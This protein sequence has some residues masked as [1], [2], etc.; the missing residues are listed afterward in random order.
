MKNKL[1]ILLNSNATWSPSGYGQ[2]AGQFLPLMAGDGHEC[3][4]IAYDGL[5]A[6][7]INIGG[8]TYLPRI[9]DPYG[10]DAILEHADRYKPDLIFTLQDVWTINNLALKY[11]KDN[12]FKWV[13]IVPV[14]HEPVPSYILEKL[15][16]A[17]RIITISRF[18]HD[19]L[20]KNGFDST[21]I[22]HTVDTGMFRRMEQKEC[23]KFIGVPDNVFLFGMVA[24]NKENPPRKSFQQVLDAFKLFR[25]AQPGSAIY[26][27]TLMDSVDGFPI[28]RYAKFL[29]LEKSVYHS[30]RY[31]VLYD[32]KQEEMPR[33]Y[34]A[35]DVL[36][37]P[38][39]RE[40]FG[41]PIIEAQACEVPAIVNDFTSMRELVNEGV[42]GYKVKVA[43]KRFTQ[44]L[45][46]EGVPDVNDLYEKMAA[47][48]RADR[49]EMGKRGR[50]R[51]VK[52]YDTKTVYEEKWRPF[53]K[54]I[55]KDL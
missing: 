12:G 36:L 37:N 47:S 49:N 28:Q 41:I 20:K 51:V 19:E 34:G 31:K 29:G 3:S 45:S 8:I 42:D 40:G 33:I 50:E 26:F 5:Q 1:K 13:P 39:T 52:E 27:H 23:R 22:P 7:I 30:E 53:L 16:M 54:E 21:Y 9:N 18:G 24:A 14:D 2:Q 15:K 55:S 4:C 32:I 10:A 44:L 25:D 11:L 48:F 17:Y 46:Y 38:S 35:F 43:Y 6:G